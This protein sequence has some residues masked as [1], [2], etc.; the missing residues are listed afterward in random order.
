VVRVDGPVDPGA[1]GAPR[2]LV[3]SADPGH[4]RR[5]RALLEERAAAAGAELH[6]SSLDRAGAPR[7]DGHDVVV[8]L[9][10]LVVPLPSSI[11]VAASLA[12]TDPQ[13][14]VAGK[15]VAADGRL[16]AAG[17]TV[18]ADRSA[19]LV[20]SGCADARAPWHEYV[21]PVCWAPGLVAA[22]AALWAAVEVPGHRSGRD[23]VREWCAAVWGSGGRVHYQ[24]LVSAVRVAGGGDEPVAPLPD[25]AWQRV[26]D[27]RPAR[28]RDLSDGAWRYLLAHDDVEGS[29]A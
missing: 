27:L 18:F 8:L 10:P 25:S 1:P 7:W 17:G 5:W 15:V 29:L 16:E 13:L 11:E 20:A 12:A 22:P 14:A 2:C 23:L 24:P 3:W 19:A 28:P 4:D 6:L 21:R 9:E 26:V